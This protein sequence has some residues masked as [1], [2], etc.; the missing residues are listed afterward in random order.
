MDGRVQEPIIAYLKGTCGKTY[1]DTITEPGVNDVL[2]GAGD[3][4]TIEAI[5]GFF[6]EMVPGVMFFLGVSNPEKGWIGMPHSPG[7][8]ADEEAIFTGASAMA[9][10]LLDFL[11]ASTDT[12]P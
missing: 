10:I 11:L 12:I 6:Q 3:A 7:Y 5:F 8:V 1:V 9:A 4:R 2:G